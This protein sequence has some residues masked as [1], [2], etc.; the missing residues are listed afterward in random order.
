MTIKIGR[1]SGDE[2]LR[3]ER[4]T[5]NGKD[6]N[7]NTNADEMWLLAMATRDGDERWRREMAKRDGD[8]RWRRESPTREHD[9]KWCCDM[10]TKVWSPGTGDKRA[11]AKETSEMAIEKLR[12][13]NGKRQT[14][15]EIRRI[16]NT[17]KE[18]LKKKWQRWFHNKN[19]GRSK[20]DEK[21]RTKKWRGGDSD[22]KMARRKQRCKNE[23]EEMVRKARWRRYCDEERNNDD[24][25]ATNK[26]RWRNGGQKMQWSNC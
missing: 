22:K 7:G 14:Q 4:A 9:E 26:Q 13:T 20:H 24:R 5:T 15:T 18:L 19:M 11:T 23:D 6:R 2:E 12:M 16:I 1:R 8:D 21:M 17:G 10:A 25:M 3:Q